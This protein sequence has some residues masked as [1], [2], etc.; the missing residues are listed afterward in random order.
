MI[1]KI[2]SRIRNKAK[3]TLLDYSSPQESE[4]P[5][6]TSHAKTDSIEERNGRDLT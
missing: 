1:V 4:T 6:G 3:C 5:R 2:L